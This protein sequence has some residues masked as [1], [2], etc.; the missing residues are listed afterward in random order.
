MRVEYHCKRDECM[1]NEVFVEGD[2]D[3]NIDK[4]QICRLRNNSLYD[5]CC[6]YTGSWYAANTETI[7][8]RQ[9]SWQPKKKTILVAKFADVDGNYPREYRRRKDEGEIVGAVWKDI[10]MKERASKVMIKSF[11]IELCYKLH[12]VNMLFVGRFSKAKVVALQKY[13][14]NLQEYLIYHGGYGNRNEIIEAL[15]RKPVDFFLCERTTATTYN[16]SF[17]FNRPMVNAKTFEKYRKQFVDGVKSEARTR[18]HHPSVFKF[19]INTL[20]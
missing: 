12:G 17:R 7:V 4:L 10:A 1:N 9:A 11:P 8:V 16:Y 5:D 15:C 6:N 13:F 19:H 14:K 3:I 20:V 18:V 2:M